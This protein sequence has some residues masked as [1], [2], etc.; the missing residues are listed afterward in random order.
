M[1]QF[2]DGIGGNLSLDPGVRGEL[3]LNASS[4]RWG[5]GRVAKDLEVSW[6]EESAIPRV[7]VRQ[8]DEHSIKPKEEHIRLQTRDLDSRY[9]IASVTLR[10][11]E[12][13]VLSPAGAGDL[14]DQLAFQDV[15]PIKTEDGLWSMKLALAP[16]LSEQGFELLEDILVEA[17][18]VPRI[19]DIGTIDKDIILVSLDPRQPNLEDD[20]AAP[21]VTARLRI[22]AT[23]M[24]PPGS[25]L[26]QGSINLA[27]RQAVSEL[28]RVYVDVSCISEDGTR[29]APIEVNSISREEWIAELGPDLAN[30]LD[31]SPSSQLLVE[32]EMNEAVLVLEARESPESGEGEDPGSDN[33]P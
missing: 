20:Y 15:F 16:S 13:R 19:E 18:I 25:S 7:D 5:V 3:T 30:Q 4:V 9:E 14:Q 11:T 10:P 2:E 17:R 6:A 22:R 33:N 23:N 1:Q 27:L 21:T 8:F 28:A 32:L 29:T 26:E 24:L 31:L 12:A